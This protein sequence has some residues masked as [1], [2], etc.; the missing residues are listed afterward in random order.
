MTSATIPN[1]RDACMPRL[2][3]DGDDW[4]DSRVRAMSSDLARDAL[5]AMAMGD[6]GRAALLAF[7][8]GVT[9]R[10]GGLHLDDNPFAA[11]GRM[12]DEWWRG[13]VGLDRATRDERFQ[14]TAVSRETGARRPV[15][16]LTHAH[17]S[18]PRDDE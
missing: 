12:G 11:T 5:A 1:T 2:S 13:W 8:A 7:E 18:A 14:L 17:A 6:L 10:V 4:F 9:G 3:P 16:G 15:G